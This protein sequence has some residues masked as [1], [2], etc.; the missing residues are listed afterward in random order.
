MQSSAQ[1]N[2]AKNHWGTRM[3]QSMQSVCTI[4]AT[5]Q[6][7]PELLEKNLD[8]FLQQAAEADQFLATVADNETEQLIDEVE[9]MRMQLSQ[10]RRLLE[11]HAQLLSKWETEIL[12]EQSLDEPLLC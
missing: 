8:T 9:R 5:T 4:I 10:G 7:N 2:D 12:R 6:N 11:N 3:K 1:P